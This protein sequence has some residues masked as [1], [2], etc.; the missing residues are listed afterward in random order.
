MEKGSGE[1]GATPKKP[2]ITPIKRTPAPEQDQTTAA[3]MPD[4]SNV[5]IG[6]DTLQ[7]AICFLPLEPPIYQCKNGHPSCKNCLAGLNNRC[8]SCRLPI[9]EIRCR[10]LEAVLA[11]MTIPCAFAKNGCHETFKYTAAASS[12]HHRQASIHEF[13]CRHAPCECPFDGCAFAGAAANLFAHIKAAHTHTAASPAAATF[14][15]PPPVTSIDRTPVRLPK[16]V[17]F[18][19]LL[20]E[21]DAAVFLLL[22]G[23]GVPKGR[24]L[25]VVC[26][27]PER[28]AAELYT[29]AVS[30]G[31][32]ALS[33]SGSVP[34][35]RRWVRY[36][37]EGFLFVPDAYWS[38]SGSV[39]VTV[40]V[41]K[42][43]SEEEAV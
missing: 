36:P 20:R 10:P 41:K 9:G 1:N 11:G 27:G 37:T 5:S 2:R 4:L 28:D 6:P 29:M 13:S 31:A 22:N 33:A 32:L 38:S 17:P 7:C 24:S 23:G 39:S 15:T 14:S 3:T 40:H 8:P 25:S 43:S 42:L 18:H 35:V 12:R 26:V 16:C 30:G 34:C 21:D 19:V